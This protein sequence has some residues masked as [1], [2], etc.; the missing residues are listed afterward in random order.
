[1]PHSIAVLREVASHR[2][3]EDAHDFGEHPG[4]QANLK[5][6]YGGSCIH[7]TGAQVKYRDYMEATCAQVWRGTKDWFTDR[8]IL[9]DSQDER[10]RHRRPRITNSISKSFLREFW[11][12][13]LFYLT[14]CTWTRRKVRYGSPLEEFLIAL[15][16]A[17]QCQCC[18]ERKISEP[19][20]CPD[21]EGTPDWW[22]SWSW[23]RFRSYL[24]GVQSLTFAQ[25]QLW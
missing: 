19:V 1:M 23:F 9:S 17:S 18:L 25:R 10:G 15:P 20:C 22:P 7:L 24:T 12:F 2:G 8:T 13:S 14:I 4:Y 16:L 11:K 6:C 5:S 3:L 21:Q